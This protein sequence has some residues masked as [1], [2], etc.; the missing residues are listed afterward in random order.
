MFRHT[1]G[2]IKP[3]K[4]TKHLETPLN[5][6]TQRLILLAFIGSALLFLPACGS[7]NNVKSQKAPET[8]LNPEVTP[9]SSGTAD[10]GMPGEKDHGTPINTYVEKIKR[11][12]GAKGTKITLTPS[13]ESS[14]P[15]TTTAQTQPNQTPAM[16]TAAPVAKSGGA[17]WIWWVI[18]IVV[19]GGI[20]WYFWSKSQSGEH[21][22]PMPPTGGLSPVS[23]FTAVKDRIEDDS[24]VETSFWTKKL[25]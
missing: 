4:I 2:K 11:T 8:V 21:S 17:H 10:I 3:S 7:K 18:L 13:T 5:T 25:F 22:Q 9:V 1:L 23:G 14:T 24:E 19:L 15:V 6:L 16:E 20:G 12:K